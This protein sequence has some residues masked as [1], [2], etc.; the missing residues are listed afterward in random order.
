MPKDPPIKINIKTNI[1]AL[2]KLP[3]DKKVTV[4]A[5]TIP[6]IP[7]KLPCLEVSGED[8]PQSKNK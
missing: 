1:K 2:E 7:N 6:K 5:I 8:N 4:T 3:V